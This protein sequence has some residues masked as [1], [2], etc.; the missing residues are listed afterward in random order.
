M[1]IRQISLISTAGF[2]A[3][4]LCL[5]A[6]AIWGRAELNK[7]YLLQSEFSLLYDEMLTEVALPMQAYLSNS[8]VTLLQQIEEKLVATDASLSDRF[9]APVVESL[10]PVIKA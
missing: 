2:F 6:V 1:K 7:P 3:T 4:I 5:I 8:D 9:P 10:A